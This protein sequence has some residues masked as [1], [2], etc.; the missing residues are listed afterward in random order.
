MNDI[1]TVIIDE[2]HVA[3][4]T[5]FTQSLFKFRPYYLIGLTATPDRADGLHNLYKPFFED[6]QIYYF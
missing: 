2:A 4:K 6:L 5:C 3:T 1:G